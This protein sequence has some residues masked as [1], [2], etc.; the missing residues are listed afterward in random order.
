M[1]DTNSWAEQFSQEQTRLLAALGTIPS[2]GII[3]SSQHVGATSWPD[4]PAD[5]VIDL[6]LAVWPFPLE[7]AQQAALA[8]LGYTALPTGE[9]AKVLRFRHH[10]GRR[11]LHVLTVGS[12]E[13]ADYLVVNEYL[14]QEQTVRQRYQAWRA[15]LAAGEDVEAAKATYLA[16]LQPAANAWW[17]EHHGF[18]PLQAVATELAGFDRPWYISSGWALDLYLGRVT[19]V[20]HD[21]D[22]VVA[23]HDQLALQ[24]YMMARGWQFVTPLQGKLEPWPRHMRI[25]LPRHQVHAHRAGAFIDFLLTDLAD[26]SW[27]YRRQ[28]VI[29]RH[30]ERMSLTTAE[31]IRYLAPELVLLYKSRNTSGQERNKDQDDFVN[32]YPNLEAERR[33]WLRW[34]L[35]ATEPQHGWLGQL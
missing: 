25:E 21:V 18:T 26:G 24:E 35:V 19:R 34:A 32:V 23:R 6:A 2:G 5:A 1:A 29:I 30:S 9:G 17:I 12:Q 22:V 10:S 20:H 7:P 16:Q 27:R 33:A 3:E 11:Q 28:P 13:W 31:G 4:A 14:Q 8:G 15:S